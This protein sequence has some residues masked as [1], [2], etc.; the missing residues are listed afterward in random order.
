MQQ[1]GQSIFWQNDFVFSF[2]TLLCSKWKVR[3]PPFLGFVIYLLSRCAALVACCQINKHLSWL[4]WNFCA[5]ISTCS[6]CVTQRI[7]L[8]QISFAKQDDVDTSNLPL[9]TGTWQFLRKSCQICER[10]QM[11]SPTNDTLGVHACHLLICKCK[12]R[13][14]FLWS[15]TCQRTFLLVTTSRL[16]E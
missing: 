10:S 9:Q 1:A 14:A 5:S 8:R 15:I 2:S 4:H 13:K 7:S 16:I 3:A 12:I 11:L 6:C